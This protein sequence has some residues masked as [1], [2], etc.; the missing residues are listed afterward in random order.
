MELASIYGAIANE[1]AI[2]RYIEDEERVRLEITKRFP[3]DPLSWIHASSFYNYGRSNAA[4]ALAM[5]EKGSRVA[6]SAGHFVV[7]AYQE[8]CRAAKE[9]GD[10]DT[11]TKVIMRLLSYKP[12]PRSMDSA[13]EC[14][15][16]IGLPENAVSEDLASRLR[17]LCKQ[18]K[19]Q[20][21]T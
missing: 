6:E 16:L 7:H 21:T 3:N 2:F 17:N 20:G 9:L 13:Y 8:Q 15:F 14:D 1:H 18:P 12:P 5:A 11:M 10:Y 19:T 4:L